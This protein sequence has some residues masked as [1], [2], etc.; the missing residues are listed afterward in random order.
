MGTLTVFSMFVA[1]ALCIE[2]ICTTPSRMTGL[3]AVAGVEG[4]AEAAGVAGVVAVVGAGAGVGAA[5][6]TYLPA[7]FRT[8]SG[9]TLPKLP[10][11]VIDLMSILL[12]AA[13]FFAIGV[14]LAL[15]VPV[16]AAGGGA[17]GAG[18]AGAATA[19]GAAGAAAG[20]ADPPPEATYA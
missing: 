18:G 9:N 12:S 5:G 6:A 19:T 8:S 20:V 17:G 1:T 11:P 16:A 2:S 10:V 7:A 14:A 13:S 3:V 15:N 4:A